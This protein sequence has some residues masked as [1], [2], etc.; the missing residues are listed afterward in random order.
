MPAKKATAMKPKRKSAKKTTKMALPVQRKMVIGTTSDVSA[1]FAEIDVGQQL[2]E[3]NTRMYRQGKVY[4]CKLEA[5]AEVVAESPD[6]ELEVFVLSNNWFNRGAWNAA[7]DSYRKATADE[8]AELRD[9]QLARWEDFRVSTGLA[10]AKEIRPGVW[11]DPTV[12]APSFLG[13]GEFALSEAVAEETG[14]SYTYNWDPTNTANTLSIPTEY[15]SMGY[16]LESTSPSQTSALAG[17]STLFMDT[18][19]A[20]ALDLQ[21]RGANPP[22]DKTNYPPV[23]CKVASISAK[24][25]TLP[26]Q[27][28]VAG[29]LSTGYFDALCGLVFIRALGTGGLT[30]YTQ[31]GGLMLEVQSG[32]YKGVHAEKI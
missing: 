15:A 24:S 28:N 23:W 11:E 14:T 19:N 21:S 32:D 7:Y 5:S 25:M 10:T 26:N 12:Q 13:N 2:S 4:R 31:D 1:G 9:S 22:Y 27:G 30:N 8:R 20:Q 29:R 17:Y 3:V 16:D 6:L 18:Q